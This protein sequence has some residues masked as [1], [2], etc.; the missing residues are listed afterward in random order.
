M[1]FALALL[2]VALASCVVIQPLTYPTMGEMLAVGEKHNITWDTGHYSG[3]S[4]SIWIHFNSTAAS[5]QFENT[6][7]DFNFTCVENDGF[8]NLDMTIPTEAIQKVVDEITKA[9]GLPDVDMT[10]VIDSLI[11]SINAI[12][13]DERNMTISITPCNQDTVYFES[14]AY[15]SAAPKVFVALAAVLL[16]MLFVF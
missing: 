3:D 8:Q 11:S 10:W 6:N 13:M 5:D 7:G 1:K 12:P 16:A 9:F 15:L 4:V 2:F 14:Y